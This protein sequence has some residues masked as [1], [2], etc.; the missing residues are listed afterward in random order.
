[1]PDIYDYL[2]KGFEIEEV[3]KSLDRKESPQ[4]VFNIAGSQKAS[5]TA[6]LINAEDAAFIITYSD[7]QVQK[8]V[9]DLQTWFPDREII[10]FP[11]VEWLTFE[12]LGRSHEITGDRIKV[13]GSLSGGEKSIIVASVQ[14]IT[15]RLFT[16]ERWRK[17]CLKFETG[18]S[19]VLTEVLRQ[20]INSGYERQEIVEGKGQFAL[21]GGI[22]D[23]APLDREPVRI[24]FFDEE[25]D[26]LRTFD[27]EN[28][29]SLQS[30]SKTEILPALEYV[31]KSKEQQELKW[32]LNSVARKAIVRF[33]RLGKADIAKRL[34]KK[35][36][37]LNSSLDE[38]TP[39][40]NIYPYLS[41][42]SEQLVSIFEWLSKEYIVFLDEP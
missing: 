32:E 40:E 39:D 7:E 22:L 28:Q 38:G 30:I 20:L 19:Y 11:S 17:N 1:M 2:G 16:P 25:V 10:V 36:E 23:I 37:Y 29:K 8:W 27:L 35:M 41:L 26:S 9:D 4:M 15:M 14:S 24:E 3:E 12:V 34:V 5:F 18:K 31:L 21:R 33:Q 42:L 13:L 6:R